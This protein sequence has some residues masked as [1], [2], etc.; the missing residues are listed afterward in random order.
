MRAKACQ[1]PTAPKAAATKDRFHR[2]S[3]AAETSPEKNPAMYMAQ[4]A[5]G[6]ER[7]LN[8]QPLEHCCLNAQLFRNTRKEKHS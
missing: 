7:V 3:I 6:A 5:A 1:V 2:Q 8:Q 4:L